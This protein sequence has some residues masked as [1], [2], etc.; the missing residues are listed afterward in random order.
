MFPGVSLGNGNYLSGFLAALADQ[1]KLK[2]KKSLEGL[3]VQRMNS[4][5]SSLAERLEKTVSGRVAPELDQVGINTGRQFNLSIL[6]LDIVGFSSWSNATHD[7]Q[8]NTLAIFDL[9]MSE[10]MNLI[11]DLGGTFEKNTGDGLMAYFGADTSDPEQAV[12]NSVLAAQRIHYFNDKYIT[13]WLQDKAS[14]SV[15]FKVGI[16]YGPVTIAKLGLKNTNSFVAIG[17]T[18]NIACHLMEKIPNGGICIGQ[19]VYSHL[20]QYLKVRCSE[21]SEYTGY[22]YSASKLPYPAWVMQTCLISE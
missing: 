15:K 18:A 4:R 6:F 2:V 11:R 10:A 3:V 22:V 17:T 14:R 12:L 5:I 7:E 13:P 1:E 19:A 16:D 20:P 8:K 9:F 21:L